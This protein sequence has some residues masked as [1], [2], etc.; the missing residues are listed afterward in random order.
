MAIEDESYWEAEYV[1][2]PLAEFA[3]LSRS[4]FEVAVYMKGDTKHRRGRHRSWNW[5]KYSAYSTNRTYSTTKPK[6][7]TGPRDAIRAVDIMISG[8]VLIDACRGLDE[9][10]RAG[11]LPQVAE[12]FGT[13][14]GETVAGWFEGKEGT[15]DTSH[16][17]HLHV[18]I[19][20]TNVDQE[21][22]YATLF[23]AIT[24]YGEGMGLTEEEYAEI[25]RGRR[26]NDNALYWWLQG[27]GTGMVPSDTTNGY[28]WT[29][30]KVAPFPGLAQLGQ[31]VDAVDDKIDSLSIPQ[32][33]PVDPEVIK[34]AVREVLYE[35][36]WLAAV[37]NAV[38]SDF[39]TRLEN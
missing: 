25:V 19:W 33:A 37:A 2:K 30:P 10:V 8:Q 26:T 13:L 5:D 21:P 11:K 3:A 24:K 18:G 4:T 34:A 23:E 1:P 32:P 29:K 6:D 35:P 16:L 7:L 20:T 28:D 36:E 14:D 22:W 39:A 12:W 27:V 31:K 15:S 9:Y 17:Y 38:N